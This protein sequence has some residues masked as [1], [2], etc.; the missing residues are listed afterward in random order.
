MANEFK[1]KKGLIVTG[2]TGG[3]ALDIQGSQGQLFSVTD[4]LSGSIFAVSDI[5]GVP[6]LDVNSSGL[7]TIDGPLTQTGGGDSN[8]SGDVNIKSVFDFDTTTDL[9]SITNNQNTGGINLSGNNSRIYFGG[10]RAIEGAQGGTNL[11][12]AEGYTSSYFQSNVNVTGDV[13][14]TGSSKY[15]YL[16]TG[17][18][19]GLWQEDDFSLR[20]GTNNIEALEL[21]NLQNATFA[22]DVTVSGNIDVGGEIIQTS[23]GNENSFSSELNM[24]SNKINSLANPTTA[25]DAATK[26]Y[27]DAHGGGLGPF[28]PLTAG[29]GYPLTDTLYVQENGNKNNGTI[30]MGLG[31]SGTSKWSFLTGTHYNQAT[32]SGNGSGSAGMAII[33]GLATETYNKVY[34][35]GGPYEINAATQI[36]FWTHSGILSTQ[37]GTRR[38][39]VNSGGDWF[40]ADTLWV[41]NADSKVGIGTTSPQQKLH[42]A[43]KL[44]VDNGD[45]GSVAGDAI[46]HAEITGA[47]HHLDF[48]EVRTADASDWKNTTY[49]LQMR[50]DSTNHQSIDFVSDASYNEHIDIY[51]GNQ[52]FNTRF[53]HDGNV[54][55]G[56]TSPSAPLSLGNGGSESLELNHNISSSSRILSYNRSNNSYRTLQ[57]D[58]LNHIF[59]TSSNERMRI[60]S[61]GNVGIGT[62]SPDYKL[63]VEGDISLVGGGE[64]YAIM[65]PINQGMQ[66]AV[67]DPADVATPLV[68][69][70]GDQ[71]VGIGTTSPSANLEIES[72]SDPEISI[73]STGGAT[74]NYLNFKATSHTQPIQSQIKTVDNNDFTADLVF[75]FKGI[76]TGGALSEKMRI[77]AGGN[78]GIGTTS[79]GQKLDVDGSIRGSNIYVNDSTVPSIYMERG[80]GL[81]Q[82]IIQLVRSNDNLIIGNTA[83]DEVLFYDDAG[84]A[85]RL[86]GSGKLG[87]G[88]T[89]PRDILEIEGNMRFVN[90]EDHLLIK[91]NNAI[92]GADFIVG[93][94]VDPADTPIMSLDGLSG[95]K[96]TIET[97]VGSTANADKT[98]L[99]IQG[100]Q[101]QLFSVTDD[102]SGDIFSV[103]DISGV[104]IMNVNSDGTSYFDGNVGIGTTS[105]AHPLTVVQKIASIGGTNNAKTISINVNDSWGYLTTTAANFYINK[106]IR[107]DTGEIG[108]YNEDLQL[109]TGG[110]TRVA[111]LNSNG[112]VGIGTTSPGAKLEVNGNIKLSS[113]AGQTA[114][115]SN[116]WLGNDYS[117]GTT[118]D[119][120]KIYLY[121]SGTEQYGFTVGN[122]SDIQY[123]SNQE[124][125]FYVAN[126]L[127]V[128]IN[129]SGNVGIGTT[130]P[131]EKLEVAGNILFNNSGEAWIKGYDNY[132]S[133]KF[134][135]GG[136][137]KTEYYEYG[138]TLAAGLGHKFFTGGTTNQTLKF[139][140]A[141]DGAYFSGNVGIG[142]TSPSDT[143]EVEGGVTIT[144]ETPTKLLLNNTKNGTWTAGEALGLV[145]FYGNDASGGGAK[146]QSS[147]DVVAQDQYGAHFNMA[148]SLSNGSGGNS[149]KMRITG[150]GKLGIGTT[151]PLATLHIDNPQTANGNIGMISD[152]SAGGTG[153]RNIHVNLPNY[154][155]GIRFLRSGTYSGGA[156]KFYSGS[157]NVGS[158]QINASST[159]YNTTSDYRAKENIAPMENS[160]DRLKELKPCRFNFLI[161]PENT[162]D[163]FIAHEAQEVVPEAVTGEKDKLDYEGNPDYQGIDQSKLV[164][165]LTAALQE[166]IN[167]IE[168]LETR[169]QTLEN[170]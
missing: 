32:G 11:T 101:G 75:S 168:Q 51:T 148:F 43:G 98:T 76:G 60:T 25:Q 135:A 86:D 34:I 170:N 45:L 118:R 41:D 164:P 4:D 142:T 161:D 38:G 53:A 56:T 130:S 70:S 140:V 85:M 27:V 147:I 157:S 110:N 17:T 3:T 15:I 90:G 55:I 16:R 9:F 159:S 120:L 14:L 36:D 40:L 156:M 22:A 137:N 107:V 12:F 87:I 114:T 112:N 152:A 155:E 132:H 138:G 80:D 5:S 73:A 108:S 97:V 126:S 26:A 24:G 139:Q 31:G 158:V 77:E 82:P 117:N 95:G 79:P 115:P 109:K 143:L 134:R 149:E 127:K 169:I 99:D 131:G 123:H 39:Y 10:N 150:E 100:S 88:V 133:I 153:T 47:R 63:D 30:S 33:G 69:F 8:F 93:D 21:D 61:G 146:V 96:V 102:L 23:T 119:K 166:A 94:G 78:V 29:S 74:S 54:G 46:Y 42:V 145:E 66:I 89:N 84:E 106:G 105:P 7:V 92:H 67:G 125:D 103:A 163:G 62:T 49:K 160:I 83:I 124:H 111:I 81:P 18:N 122:Q 52:V 2:A 57:F 162:V 64:N 113:T 19:S 20:F 91:P 44:L 35:G 121:N 151:S 68:T 6:I 136:T 65:S 58:G 128:R 28:L 71:K 48:K 1:I 129:Q 141:D 167:K 72:A 154:G 37:G 165:L 104:P 13:A 144:S 59:K 116:I 50:V